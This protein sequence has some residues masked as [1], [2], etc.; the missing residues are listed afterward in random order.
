MAAVISPTETSNPTNQFIARDEILAKT[1]SQVQVNGLPTPK[2]DKTWPIP[3]SNWTPQCHSRVTDVSREVDGYF[4]QHWGFP[5]IKSE[6]VFLNAGFSRVTCLYFPLAQDDRIHFACRLLTLLFL[7][8]DLLEDMSFDEGSA[9]NEKLIPVARGDVLPDRN[10]P[11]EYITYDLWESMRAC[12]KELADEVLEPTFTFMRA[13][14]DKVRMSITELGQYLDYRE[15]DVGKALLSSLMRFAMD[16]RLTPEELVRMKPLEQN[17]S[18]QIS[19]VNDIF[20]WEKEL[21]AA[22]T[23]HKEGSFLC[24]AMK[25]FSVSTSLSIEASRRMLWHMTREWEN[26][27]DEMVSRVVAEG[28]RDAVEAYMKGLEFQMSGNELWSKTTLRY[29]KLE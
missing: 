24:S 12:D 13:Q 28:C 15:K 3:K 16:L 1:Q 5:N 17:C 2:A 10:V 29:S 19:V 8:D 9:Y 6:R 23:G 20:S 18:K 4:L 14:T 11:A 21:R 25:V 7:I 27:H 22:E 26:V